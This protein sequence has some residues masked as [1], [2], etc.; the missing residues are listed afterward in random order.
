MNN[1]QSA[2]HGANLLQIIAKMHEMV[3]KSKASM[4]V[5]ALLWMFGRRFGGSAGSAVQQVRWFGGFAGFEGSVCPQGGN[6]SP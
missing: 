1:S 4:D 6:C 5:G 3:E 2:L